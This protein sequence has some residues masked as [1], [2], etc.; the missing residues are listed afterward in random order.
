MTHR[1]RP[2]LT[3]TDPP[4]RHLFAPPSP[5]PA[6]PT[7]SGASERRD[8]RGE[9]REALDLQ[10]E[11]SCRRSSMPRHRLGPRYW[12]AGS[13]VRWF[14]WRTGAIAVQNETT[15]PKPLVTTGEY[16][17]VA[18]FAAST[19]SRVMRVLLFLAESHRQAMFL[20]RAST[21][22]AKLHS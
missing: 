1:H 9:G 11:R 4:H 7:R 21:F 20:T 16:P 3:F 6:G 14:G 12:F 19:A 10:R 22:Q 15:T 5:P 2:S 18:Q 8:C 17:D 13:V